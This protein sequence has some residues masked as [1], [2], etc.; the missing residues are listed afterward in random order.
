MTFFELL[1]IEAAKYI[2][3]CKLQPKMHLASQH[4]A[5][6]KAIPIKCF[7]SKHIV[8]QNAKDCRKPPP[9]V[10]FLLLVLSINLLAFLSQILQSDWLLYSLVP[11]P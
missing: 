4:S 8:S 2:G 9:R 11:I 7:V 10:E 3:Q 6:L 5:N 1:A